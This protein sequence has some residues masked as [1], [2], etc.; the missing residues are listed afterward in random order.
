MKLVYPKGVAVAGGYAYALFDQSHGSTRLDVIDVRNPANPSLI[1]GLDLG[2]WNTLGS[3]LV[4]GAYLYVGGP[5]GG[6]HVFDVRAPA[7]PRRIG[8]NSALSVHDLAVDGDKLY[9]A[10][11]AEGLVVLNLFHLPITLGTPRFSTGGTFL[12]PIS[13]E[14]GS[15]ARL[16]RS[17]NLRDWEDWVSLT[18][19]DEPTEIGD[20]DAGSKPHVFYRAVAP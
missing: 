19:A 20:P 15:T 17:T 16:Q 6:L 18:L 3:V 8:G 11:G 2:R 1:G 13:G 14:P 9:V 5:H 7:Q 12:L 4:K 10:D